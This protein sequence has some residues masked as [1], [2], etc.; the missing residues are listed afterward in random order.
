MNSHYIAIKHNDIN[1]QLF[2]F[3]WPAVITLIINTITQPGAFDYT[4]SVRSGAFVTLVVEHCL[5]AFFDVSN[6]QH[7]LISVTA[8]SKL[9]SESILTRVCRFQIHVHTSCSHNGLSNPYTFIRWMT[10]QIGYL[11]LLITRSILSGSLDFEIKGVACISSLTTLLTV[12]AC[13]I[14]DNVSP[15]VG[16][17]HLW[18][19]CSL[20]WHASSLTTLFTVLTCF[21]FDN[22]AVCIGMLH[23]WQHFSLCWHTSSLTT[24]LSVLVCMITSLTTFLPMLAYFIFDSI[25]L[26]IGML[27]LLQHC[28]LCW[29]ASSLTTLLS[30]LACF[31]F[32]NMSPY[33]GMLHLWQHVSLCWHAS[34][35]TMCLPVLACFIFDNLSPCLDMLHL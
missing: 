20:Y 14:F 5:M 23:V 18:Q 15:C 10:S 28:S 17:L 35:L 30:V 21:I 19:H 27:H 25:A 34:F 13:F 12:L 6:H 24:L 31:I 7:S 33:V 32:D 8:F 16:M 22:I 26:N 2:T 29:H 11:K 9:V 1:D 4:Q 3:N